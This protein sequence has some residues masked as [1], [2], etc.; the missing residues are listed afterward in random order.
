MWVCHQT[1][2]RF[3]LLHYRTMRALET[4]VL[5]EIWMSN[6]KFEEDFD[7]RPEEGPRS[8]T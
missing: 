5:L 8:S 6:W 1:D 4:M 7:I 3:L 2:M